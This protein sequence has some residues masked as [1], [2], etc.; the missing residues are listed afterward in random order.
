MIV[1]LDFNLAARMDASLAAYWGGYA[2]AE[3]AHRE[4]FPGASLFYTPIP[5][6]LFNTVI[7]TGQDAA[8][9]D[10]VFSS[11][12]KCIAE[13][14]RPILWRLS[15][16]AVSDEVTT[17]LEQYGLQQ[18]GRDPAMLANLSELPSPVQ[19]TG[20]KIQAS[21]GRSG[22]YD[23]ARL[24]CD[25]FELGPD[26]RKAMSECEAAIPESEFASQPRYVGY[27]D[28]EP[29]AVS[30]LVMTEGLAGVYAVATLPDARN[31]GIGTAMT[32]H[33]M[34]E[35]KMRGAKSA[36]LQATEIGKSVYEGIGFSTAY[37]YEL[38]L[39]T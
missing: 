32:L 19:I 1:A 15:P 27:L 18:Q 25:A 38:Y 17:R 5:L 6:S 14:G 13:Q 21:E 31:R 30:S 10:G 3:G 24:T 11:A 23:W 29:V 28:G 35:G 8:S 20:L 36:V 16:T 33:V 7:L 37:E 26:V 4:K 39:Q 12:A 34:R 9:I 22:R 2:L